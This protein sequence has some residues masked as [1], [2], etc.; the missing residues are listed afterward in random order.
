MEESRAWP[1]QLG[2]GEPYPDEKNEILADWLAAYL[3]KK[4]GNSTGETN[5]LQQISQRKQSKNR[6]ESLLQ[7][8]A[9]QQLANKG[10]TG[11]CGKAAP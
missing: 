6:Y 9:I 7:Q 2:V 11:G 4:I 10:V 1:S 8:A 3:Q 5:L